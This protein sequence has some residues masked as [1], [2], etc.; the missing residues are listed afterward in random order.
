VTDDDDSKPPILKVVSENPN[1]RTDREIERARMR[2]KGR[3]ADLA[4]T[5]LRM[6]AGSESAS[7]DLMRRMRDLIDAQHELHK[8]S[9]EWLSVE[10]E[11]AAL[12][13]P[14]S[15]LDSAATDHDYRGWQRHKGMERIV[16]G[17]LRLAAHKIL[18]EDPHFG[19]KHS[20]E[21]IQQGIKTLEELKRPIPPAR[22]K[23]SA[24][25]DVDPGPP[26]ETLKRGSGERRRSD[27]FSQSD[28]RELRK[29]IKAK[30]T[31]RIAELTAK[32]GKPSFK[33]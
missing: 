16:Q 20:V 22:P 31:K 23:A 6:L 30:D 10:D 12:S 9:G 4:A 27:G 5:M 2:A 24:W 13:L 25:A 26:A 28:L 3:L 15:D 29:A 32:L 19:G 11:Q 33:E 18:G 7:F 21:V 17:A 14:Q 1:A 8:L